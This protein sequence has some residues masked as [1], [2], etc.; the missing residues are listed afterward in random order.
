M[1]CRSLQIISEEV[2]RAPVEAYLTFQLGYLDR[3]DKDGKMKLRKE[4][5]R[6]LKTAGRWMYVDSEF[7]ED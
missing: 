5:S 1:D 6:F 4:K 3:Q 7:I 2:G